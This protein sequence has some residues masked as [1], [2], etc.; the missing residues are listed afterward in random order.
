MASML[1]TVPLM[2]RGGKTVLPSAALGF[3]TEQNVGIVG[4]DYENCVFFMDDGSQQTHGEMTFGGVLSPPAALPVRQGATTHDMY[5]SCDAVGDCRIEAA[6]SDSV[7][8]RSATRS[9]FMLSS[10]MRPIQGTGCTCY[11]G[12]TLMM[13]NDTALLVKDLKSS[14]GTMGFID[15]V[16]AILR[17]TSTVHIVGNAAYK[18]M[19]TEPSNASYCIIKVEG[20]IRYDKAVH[21]GPVRYA[22]HQ[23]AL[24]HHAAMMYLDSHPWALPCTLETVLSRLG[25]DSALANTALV[26][27]AYCMT[28]TM[29]DLAEQMPRVSHE[30][31]SVPADM[32]VM[33]V[34]R[35]Q[36][37]AHAGGK[38]SMEYDGGTRGEVVCPVDLH[39][40]MECL[41]RTVDMCVVMGKHDVR[42]LLPGCPDELIA[43]RLGKNYHTDTGIYHSI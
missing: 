2:V 20:D 22:T 43:D 41:E 38:Y 8:V 37:T 15:T 11:R 12:V 26:S 40:V 19:S 7:F 13:P 21:W 34:R 42:E 39:N 23:S 16:L 10:E 32:L 25:Y 24:A 27:S 9:V 3:R 28:G 35:G 6:T 17:N 1:S 14:G 31:F 36:V 33:G 30:A 29:M 4:Y 5:A 18:N